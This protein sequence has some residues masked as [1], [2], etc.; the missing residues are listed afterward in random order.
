MEKW[1]CI[2]VWKREVFLGEAIRR[3]LLLLFFPFLHSTNRR[4]IPWLCFKQ[5]VAS[6]RTIYFVTLP[7][8]EHVQ[9]TNSTNLRLKGLFRCYIIFICHHSLHQ[10]YN[11]ICFQYLHYVRK[12]P[13]IHY[14]TSHR[15]MHW[16][17]NSSVSNEEM[18]LNN[19]LYPLTPHSDSTKLHVALD[20]SNV[21]GCRQPLAREDH[22]KF[23]AD[24]NEYFPEFNLSAAANVS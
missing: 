12:A 14:K 10:A 8:S 24:Q 17:T 19:G 3:A 13:I 20:P 5:P 1:P 7:L 23:Y 2:Q 11:Y 16:R 6:L 18:P 22:P 15:Q 21:L 4:T 9:H